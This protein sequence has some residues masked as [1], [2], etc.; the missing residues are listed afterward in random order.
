M[1]EHTA[2]NDGGQRDPVDETA[3][4][5][6]IGEKIHRQGQITPGEHCDRTLL[7]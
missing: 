5:F 4:V 2:T 3:A 6:F 7:A 1:P